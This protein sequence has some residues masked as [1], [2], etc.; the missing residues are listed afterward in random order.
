MF[1][2]EA[3]D[4]AQLSAFANDD[5][6]VVDR[7]EPQNETK[8]TVVNAKKTAGNLPGSFKSGLAGEGLPVPSKLEVTGGNSSNLPKAEALQVQGGQEG[9]PLTEANLRVFEQMMGNIK[10]FKVASVDLINVLSYPELLGY[11]ILDV[12][13]PLRPYFTRV[14][15]YQTALNRYYVEESA[16]ISLGQ[17][18]RHLV[19]PLDE[20]IDIKRTGEALKLALEDY[21]DELKQNAPRTPAE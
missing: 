4:D 9:A 17:T 10:A 1:F 16:C 15:G 18:T 7:P 11:N 21:D 6:Q 12:Y 5:W 14:L 3:L 19:E 20:L 8:W 13:P 2:A